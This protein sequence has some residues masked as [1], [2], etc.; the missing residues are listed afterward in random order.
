MAKYPGI[1]VSPTDVEKIMGTLT[2]AGEQLSNLATS[3]FE[4]EKNKV[5]SWM[6]S[7]IARSLSFGTE[8][9]STV[10]KNLSTVIK[11]LCDYFG[12]DYILAISCGDEV[13]ESMTLLY[14]YGLPVSDFALGEYDCSDKAAS[15]KGLTELIRGSSQISPLN[16][17]EY[18][19]LPIISQTYNLH[20]K[21]GSRSAV[22]SRISPPQESPAALILGRFS[23]DLK[24][25]NFSD[26]DKESLQSIV[27]DVAMVTEIVLLIERLKDAIE[28]QKIFT[29]DIAHDRRNP[30]QNIIIKADLLR[31]GLVPENEVKDQAKKLAAQVRRLHMLSQRIWTLEAILRKRLILDTNS[32]TSVYKVI[33]EC[34]AI[35]LDLAMDRGIEISVDPELEKLLPIQVD[36]DFFAQT[37]LN[38][39]DNAIKYSWKRS[40]IRIDGK[41]RA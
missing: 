10:L 32:R 33:M 9:V 29:E 26:I 5:V 21:G 27:G 12:L 6:R 36:K 20:R 23:Q 11:N 35:L 22:L 3:T 34:R 38:L 30:I 37:V 14:Q 40:E 41:Q 13:D 39:I 1:E 25:D 8:S 2:T 16:L 28:K 15:F 24:L 31:M 4:L 19:D 17:L 18:S 7:K